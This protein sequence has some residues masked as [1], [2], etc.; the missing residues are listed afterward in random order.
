MVDRIAAMLN[1]FLKSLVGPNRKSF[2]VKNLNEFSF[3][4]GEIVTD[5]CKIYVNLKDCDT[6][7]SSVSRDGRSYSPDLFNQASEVLLK[8]GSGQLVSDLKLVEKKVSHAASTLKADEELFADA[9]DEFLGNY[10]F[11]FYCLIRY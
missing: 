7:L 1:H 2:K 4:P 3:K 9:P 10:I 6:F 11:H 5:I 8:V